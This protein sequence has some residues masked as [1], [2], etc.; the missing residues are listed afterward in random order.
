MH[1]FS[2]CIVGSTLHHSVPGVYRLCITGISY[3]ARYTYWPSLEYDFVFVI[4]KML[5]PMYTRSA[6]KYKFNSAVYCFSPLRNGTHN[7]YQS[8]AI[9]YRSCNYYYVI[10]R[11][12]Y[13]SAVPSAVR[14]CIIFAM[15]RSIN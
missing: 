11:K 2:E 12:C 14:I 3:Y 13:A 6:I 4:S 9:L 5:C 15:F 7:E 1:L 8:R 10:V